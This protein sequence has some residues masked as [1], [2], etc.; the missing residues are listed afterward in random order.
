MRGACQVRM[1]GWRNANIIQK[2]KKKNQQ[3]KRNNREN[4]KKE[5]KK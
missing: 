5:N 2:K 3:T 4:L 1:K